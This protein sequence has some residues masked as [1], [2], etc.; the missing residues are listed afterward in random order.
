MIKN[1]A[2]FMAISIAL[3]SYQLDAKVVQILHT[4]D[5][6]SFLEHSTHKTA[7][8]GMPRLKALMDQYK[9]EALK[10][11]V[12]TIVLDAG[13]FLE[14][15]LYYLADN[16]KKS[17]QI[18]NEMG[19]DVG[20]LGNH[21]YLMGSEKL[22]QILAETKL[23]YSFVAA[24]LYINKKYTHLKK[25]IK[26]YAELNIDGLKIGVLGL[27]TNEAIYKWSLNDCEITDPIDAAHFYEDELK[28]RGN[29]AIIALTHLGVLND[30]KLVE[31]TSKLDLVVGGHSHTALFEP[32]YEKN[33]DGRNIPIVQAG[34]HTEYMGRILVDIVKGKP[35]KILKY[36]LIPVKNKNV[37]NGIQD[38]VNEAK[39]NLEEIFGKNTLYEI[40]GVSTLNS[41][42]ELGM[43]KW[44]LYIAETM[45]EASVADI[46]I[47][48]PSM[49]SENFPIGPFT[50]FDL[51]NSIPRI[52][53]PNNKAGW[54]IFT[55]GVKGIWIRTLFRLQAKIGE[56]LVFAGLKIDSEGKLTIN[57]EK[58]IP[59]KTYK[60]AFTEGII[61]GALA[62]S[63]K[64]FAFLRHPIQTNIKI[65]NALEGRIARDL[66]HD[67][68]VSNTN[69]GI[70]ILK[71]YQVE[72]EK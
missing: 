12:K 62:I 23:N 60:V 22:D 43:N 65:W 40:L 29:D 11:D 50:R 30:M 19:Y 17:F 10:D 56:P 67:E 51:Y 54:T 8:G 26:P 33:K 6:H 55:A 36:E 70:K 63:S 35:L 59:T 71:P 5:T 34:M 44:G 39:N 68:V 1:L 18:H 72:T 4:N 25:A 21:D 47:H 38:L 52:F 41:S 48:S 49:N 27:T 14:G 2:C 28:N 66:K 37:D 32:V 69:L 9:E 45:K 7:V 13:D 24:N 58:V 31:K 3:P 46:S 64:A 42:D 20:T 53:N 16:G 15:N 61:K 57:G